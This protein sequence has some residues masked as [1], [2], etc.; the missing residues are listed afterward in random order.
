MARGGLGGILNPGF[1]RMGN[2]RD[3]FSGFIMLS[4]SK[5]DEDFLTKQRAGGALP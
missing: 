5:K 3:T 1:G 2:A 4:V